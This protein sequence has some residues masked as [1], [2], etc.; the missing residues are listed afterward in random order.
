MCGRLR[1]QHLCSPKGL[2]FAARAQQPCCR[3]QT[4]TLTPVRRCFRRRS[5]TSPRLHR[6]AHQLVCY[7]RRPSCVAL[8]L[9][10]LRASPTVFSFPTCTSPSQVRLIRT[11]TADP[12]HNQSL[13]SAADLPRKPPPA[14]P[15][16]HSF[17]G[18]G[19]DDPA[20]PA[21]LRLSKSSYRQVSCTALYC[22]AA[23]LW[24]PLFP[25]ARL[26]SV[27]VSAG[28]GDQLC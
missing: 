26:L 25:T 1:P 4:I 24:Q 27:A 28:R 12:F 13:P 15:S 6:C 5:G 14:F 16:G 23:H 3:V 20:P 2:R 21:P 11:S 7:F 10:P 22:P 17:A 8:F 9:A 19:A 18:E